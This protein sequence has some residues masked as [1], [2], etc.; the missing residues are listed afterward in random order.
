[1][2]IIMKIE[3]LKAIDQLADFLSGTHAVAFSVI[4]DKGKQRKIYRYENMMTPYV[5]V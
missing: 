3:D 5:Q 2:K 4:S 1:M